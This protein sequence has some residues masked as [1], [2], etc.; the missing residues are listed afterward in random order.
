MSGPARKQS[1]EARAPMANRDN[2]GDG[3]EFSA[4]GIVL[5]TKELLLIQVRNLNG[6]KVWTF[7]KGHV[8]K[9]E[10]PE[11]TAIREVEEETG[12][13]CVI[14]GLATTTH[15][16][17]HRNGRLIRKRVNWYWMDPVEKTGERDY[18]EIEAVRWVA[19]D[20]IADMLRYPSDLELLKKTVAHL[21]SR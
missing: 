10:T 20:K 8:E 1:S 11:Q 21:G 12:Y 4:G 2:D 18:K 16:F 9:G 14:Q 7:P 6:D 5:G 19:I 15:Y 17:F 13:Q 3:K